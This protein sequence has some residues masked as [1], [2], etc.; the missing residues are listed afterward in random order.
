MSGELTKRALDAIEEAVVDIDHSLPVQTP[1]LFLVFNR[2]DVTARVFDAIRQARPPRLYVAADGP[3]A[4]REGEAERVAKVREIA[5]A[6]DWP[7]ELK[8][9]F[10]K[11][12]LGCKLAVGGGIT[13]FFE[14]E[15]QGIILEDDCLPH[16]DFFYFCEILLERYASD[17]R[18]TLITGDNFQNGIRRGNA[19][20]YFSKYAHI[21]GWAT[22]RRAW[23]H[24]QPDISFWPQWRDSASWAKQLPDPEERSYWEMI[25]ERVYN[26]GIDT[27][28]YPWMAS[29]WYR[30]GLTATPN[31]NLVSNIGFGRDATHTASARSPL[32]NMGTSAVSPI[33]YSAEVTRDDEADQ[34]AFDYV[35]GGRSQRFVTVILRYLPR[36]TRFFYE[37]LKRSCTQFFH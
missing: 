29:V 13:W 5:S 1:V 26:N 11:E 27:W 7:C 9:L 24:Y 10:R 18:V 35:F 33:D 19:S 20:Y 36:P 22:W 37:R 28:D 16:P 30:G 6:V 25:F 23:D 14:H 8:T 34:Y 15:E 12:N 17:E 31:V 4:N 3:R 21:W 2:P 32:A